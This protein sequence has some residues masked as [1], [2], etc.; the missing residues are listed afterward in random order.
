[1][2]LNTAQN[3]LAAMRS[4]DPDMKSLTEPTSRTR[5]IDERPLILID[6]LFRPD[7]INLFD[8]FLK[9]LPFSLAD[10]DAEDSRHVLHWIHEFSLEEITTHPLL[11]FVYSRIRSATENACPES[12]IQLKRVHCNTSLYGDI[13]FPHHDLTPGM[14][15]L[16]YSNPVWE[17]T[18]MGETIFYDSH[19]E[20]VYAV[21]PKPGRVVVFAADILHR[22]GVPSRECVEARRSLA[23]KFLN[24]DK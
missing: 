11:S 14:T 2:P 22:G 19:G 4:R 6:G 20:P 7:F 18:W 9:T 24:Q 16:Y 23:F 17:P 8:R 21:F 1:M 13:Q 5:Q 3:G 12:R 10:Y 15:W